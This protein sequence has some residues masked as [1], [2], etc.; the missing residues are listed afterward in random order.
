M[1]VPVFGAFLLVTGSTALRLVLP[2]N[3]VV[4]DREGVVVLGRR[5]PWRDIDWF[6]TDAYVS[7]TSLPF[8]TVQVGE[9]AAT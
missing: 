7:R 9:E 2:W 5:L 4:V 1:G 3:R 6:A 8:V